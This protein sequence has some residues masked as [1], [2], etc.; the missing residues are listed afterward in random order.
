MDAVKYLK[1]KARMVKMDDD[2]TCQISCDGCKLSE[3]H[4]GT[5][6]NCALFERK[7]PEK[8]VEIVEE[9]AA[10]YPVKTRQSEFLKIFPNVIKDGDEIID[11]FPCNINTHYKP[12]CED[13]DNCTR[14]REEYWNAEVE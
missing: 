1:E 4:N 8:A 13:Y 6:L 14:C 2:C 5:E 7:F 3:F 12:E 9:F 11:I 10:K